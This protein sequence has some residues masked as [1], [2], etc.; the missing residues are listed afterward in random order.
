MGYFGLG[1]TFNPET[2]FVGNFRFSYSKL[3][4][5]ASESIGVEAFC[6]FYHLRCVCYYPL[7]TTYP[8]VDHRKN[9][10][11]KVRIEPNIEKGDILLSVNLLRP[12]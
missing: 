7:K 2:F 4:V 6:L 11:F 1:L 8:K 3:S 5:E 12:N 10:R 9:T